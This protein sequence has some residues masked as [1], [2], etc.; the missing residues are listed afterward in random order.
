MFNEKLVPMKKLF[1]LMSLFLSSSVSWAETR[2]YK[3]GFSAFLYD[4]TP[5]AVMNTVNFLK[6]NGDMYTIKF[7]ESIPWRS[8]IDN[9]PL[10]GEFLKKLGEYAIHRLPNH[11]LQLSLTAVKD[12]HDGLLNDL[13]GSLPQETYNSSVIVEAYIRYCEKMIEVF[14][15][16][17][18]LTGLNS[19]E[20]YLENPN[21][22]KAYEKF[23]KAVINK[24][25]SRH[26][27]ILF[28][29]SINLNKLI[30]PEKEVK[31]TKYKR[32][33]INF[34]RHFDF[35]PVTLHP[36]GLAY[37]TEKEYQSAF[38]FLHK[39]V[40]K[41]IAIAATS[42]ISQSVALEEITLQSSQQIQNDY[43]KILFKNARKKR[44]LYVSYWMHR[45]CDALLKYLPP[46]AQQSVNIIKDAGLV[47]ENGNHRSAFNTWKAEFLRAYRK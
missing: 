25:K 45:D 7:D 9:Q 41:P 43:L 21:A 10:P 8:L 3:M 5:E 27:N 20:L 23:S 42:Q 4:H 19:N 47:D 2:P 29:E 35:F 38:D 26:R 31:K 12:S 32:D 46:A 13:D 36:F 40:R 18:V 14:R 34:S 17:Y 6:N 11:K 1:I 22:W 16:D 28:A 30:N 15:P 44:Y 39:S 24:L 37:S 33:I